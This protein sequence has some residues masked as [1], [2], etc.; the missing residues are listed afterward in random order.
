MCIISVSRFWASRLMLRRS[1]LQSSPKQSQTQGTIWLGVV[2][3]FACKWSDDDKRGSNHWW[4][5]VVFW[6]MLF[7]TIW[8]WTLS[9]HF[10]SIYIYMVPP[11]PYSNDLSCQF[12][13][14]P[15]MPIPLLLW[16]WKLKLGGGYTWWCWYYIHFT[17]A[18][19]IDVFASL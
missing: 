1:L 7:R 5:R 12:L 18:F 6:W 14:L 8:L 15:F 17:L 2:K 16:T 9:C 4:H 11:R 10:V 13:T 3:L 19:S